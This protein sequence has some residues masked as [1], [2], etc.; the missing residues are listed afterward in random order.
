MIYGN[1][2]MIACSESVFQNLLRDYPANKKYCIDN[3]IDYSRFDQNKMAG[4]DEYSLKENSF[5]CLIFGFDFYRKGV[6][7]AVKALQ[8]LNEKGANF[9]LLISLSKNF[10]FVENEINN[11]LDTVPNWIHIIKARPDVEALYNLADVF[12]SPSREEGLPYSVLEASYFNCTVVTSDISAQI[13]IDV[14]YKVIH[15][16]ENAEALANAIK[17][18]L[19][20]KHEKMEHLEEVRA[21]LHK[22]HDVS[23]WTENIIRIYKNEY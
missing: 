11:M 21:Y 1:C 19:D 23:R 22:L 17:V 16:S 8:Q 14:P 9:E 15:S 12:L 3:G 18:A 4:R 2:E 6:D 13:H 20:L 7:L 10:H 5:I